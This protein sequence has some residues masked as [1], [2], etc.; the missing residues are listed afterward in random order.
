MS[1]P[2]FVDPRQLNPGPIRHE[3][4]APDLLDTVRAVYE[5]MELAI[6]GV[7]GLTFRQG[8]VSV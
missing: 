6:L 7:S 4:L 2:T 5:V 3:S 8:N 1:D